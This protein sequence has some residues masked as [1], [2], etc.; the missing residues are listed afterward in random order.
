VLGLPA[1]ANG[2]KS[3][4][5]VWIGGHPVAMSRSSRPHLRSDPT[6]VGWTT[7]VEIVSLGNVARSTSSTRYPFRANSI[8]VGDPAHRA[9]TTIASNYAMVPPPG[10]VHPGDPASMKLPV[11]RIDKNRRITEA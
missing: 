4:A 8:A 9:P 11:R 7:W 2:P 1:I 10:P 6:P 5:Y 3:K